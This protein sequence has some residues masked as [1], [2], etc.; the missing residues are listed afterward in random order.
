VPFDLT[1]SDA[2]CGLNTQFGNDTITDFVAGAGTDDVLELGTDVFVDYAN[3]ISKVF[4]AVRTCSSRWTPT[5]AS[6]SI[7]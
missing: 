7:M 5:T 4:K 2:E 3:V 6:G 1:A